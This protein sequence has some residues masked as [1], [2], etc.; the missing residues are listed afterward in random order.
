M[1]SVVTYPLRVV[2]YNILADCYVRVPDQPWNAFTHCTEEHLVYTERFPRIIEKLIQSNADVILLQEVMFEK[3][4]DIWQL[5]EDLVVAL[6]AQGYQCVMQG[7]K[8]KEI[9]S[10]ALRNERMVGRA[11]PTGLAVCWKEERFTE[12]DDSKGRSG[13]GMTLYLQLKECHNCVLC[14]NNIHLVGD[15]QQFSQHLKQ[16]EGAKKQLNNVKVLDSIKKGTVTNVFD[17][18]CGDFNGDII[19]A[20]DEGEIVPSTIGEWFRDNEFHRAS[21][22]IS[23][24]S[25]TNSARLDHVMYRCRQQEGAGLITCEPHLCFPRQSDEIDT[26]LIG[27]LPN[28]FHPSDHVMVQ[29]DFSIGCPTI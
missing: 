8:Q 3:R 18:I 9:A 17:L 14:L 4:N 15:P 13:S 21:T 11:I 12:F 25:D 5:P 22:G 20:S 26:S 16:L 28:E 19:T 1:S 6:Q 24:A 27:G 2:S 23:W 10:N 7:L 29:V